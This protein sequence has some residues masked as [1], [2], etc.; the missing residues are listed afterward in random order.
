M[1]FKCSPDYAQEVMENISVMLMM[2]KQK[3]TLMILVP[4]LIPEMITWHFCTL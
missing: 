2:Q 1:G 3:C 4:P